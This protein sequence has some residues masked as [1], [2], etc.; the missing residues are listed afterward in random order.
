MVPEGYIRLKCPV[1]GSS[2]LDQFRMHTGH[3]Y[4]AKCREVVLRN[5]E[6]YDKLVWNGMAYIKRKEDG[7]NGCNT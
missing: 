6:L 5:K 4:C 2:D 7:N 3:I 1:C